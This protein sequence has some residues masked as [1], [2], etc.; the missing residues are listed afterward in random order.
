MYILNFLMSWPVLKPRTP[1]AAILAIV[2]T[3]VYDQTTFCEDV[4][5]AVGEYPN[6][7]FRVCWALSP[8][9]FLV[10][11]FFTM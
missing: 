3:Y 10:S 1:I 5:F 6:V 11:T 2:L 8:V 7:F 4:Y 9:I